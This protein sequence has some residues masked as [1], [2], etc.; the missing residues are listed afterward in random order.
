M[1]ESFTVKYREG[2]YGRDLR[3]EYPE[4]ERIDEICQRAIQARK[5]HV[6]FLAGPRLSGRSDLLQTLGDHIKHRFKE[7]DVCASKFSAAGAIADVA[8]NSD[9]S[10][11]LLSKGLGVAEELLPETVAKLL[12][13]SNVLLKGY[14]EGKRALSPKGTTAL[15]WQSIEQLKEYLLEMTSQR[16]LLWLIDDFDLGPIEFN[17]GLFYE[18]RPQF[19]NGLP[20][21]FLLTVNRHVKLENDPKKTDLLQSVAGSLVENKVGQWWPVRPL[22]KEEISEWLGNTAPGIIE[23]LLQTTEGYPPRVI[24]TWY[25]WQRDGYV[26]YLQEEERWKFNP[27]ESLSLNPAR[28]LTDTH[29]RKRFPDSSPQERDKLRQRL[30][31]CALEGET[32][33]ADCV[34]N[35]LERDRDDFQDWLD[36]HFVRNDEN[37]EALILESQ[38][39]RFRDKFGEEQEVWRY[40]FADTLTWLALENDEDARIHQQRHQLAL[41]IRDLYDESD[42]QTAGRLARIYEIIGAEDQARHFTRIFDY[43]NQIDLLAAR[44]FHVINLLKRSGFE[45]DSYTRQRFYDLLLEVGKGM[46]VTYPLRETFK[47]FYVATR[48]ARRAS[49]KADLVET[50]YYCS[51]ILTSL[52][53]YR[54]AR[55]I[56]KQALNRINHLL[57][58]KSKNENIPGRWRLKCLKAACLYGLAEIAR[59]QDEYE[60]ASELY[61]QGLEI[62]REIN[63]RRSEAACLNGLANLA[64]MQDEYESASE[65]YRQG[66]EIA[67]EINHRSIE[68]ECLNGQANL[69]WTQN[70][71]ESASELYRQGLEIAREINHRSIEAECLNGLAE[72][73]QMQSEY[74]KAASLYRQALEIRKKWFREADPNAVMIREALMDLRQSITGAEEATTPDE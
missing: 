52:G 50:Q 64:C 14:L 42:P 3:I 27:K 53:R 22:G 59:T 70:E 26:S 69:A 68:A 39:Y 25:Q 4:K 17:E 19:S 60:S 51:Q 37:P 35:A 67:R 43:G 16:P 34:A 73:A 74:E 29:L 21:I 46:L 61:R 13:K 11:E 65:L 56:Y 33:T 49:D 36:D 6:I 20:V 10:L 1:P 63:D 54:R 45:N 8:T 18:L 31:L 32:F 55:G 5:G 72:I 71:Y 66:L 15:L 40:R 2:T 62:A 38:L 47:V 48:I 12:K 44:A 24:K 30:H 9:A 41:A 23:M 58:S 28:N 7:I 57:T